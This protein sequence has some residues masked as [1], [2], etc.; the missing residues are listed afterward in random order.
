MEKMSGSFVIKRR[1]LKVEKVIGEN[2]IKKSVEADVTLPYKVIKVFDVM[3]NTKDVE[4]EVRH[5]GVDIS[6]TIHKQLFVVDK[7]DLVQHVAEDVPFQVY[8]PV[9]HAQADM[10]VQV[11]VRIL[12]VDTDLINARTV[13]QTVLLDIFVKVTVTEQIEV[14]TDVRGKHLKVKKEFLKVDSVVGEDL[15]YETVSPTFTLPIT[16]K[17]IFRIQAKLQDVTAETRHDS[18]TLRGMIHKQIYFV[19]EGDLVRHAREDIPFTKTINIPGARP[20]MDVMFRA[21]VTV[22]DAELLD[23]PSRRLSQTMVIEAFVKVTETLQLDVVVDVKGKNIKVKKKL[24]KV[25]SVVVDVLQTEMLRAVAKLPVQAQ[26]IFEI[27]GKIVDLETEARHGQV[28][29]KGVLH[30]QLFFVDPANLLRHAFEDVP[31]RFVK[32]APGT[33]PGMNVLARVR[34]IGNIK[35]KIVDRQGMKI[36]QTALLEVFVKVTR[37][38]QLE[39]VVDV[40]KEFP[41]HPEYPQHPERPQHPPD[42]SPHGAG[43]GTV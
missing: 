35:H 4:S 43:E 13:Q 42:H 31:F 21:K 29:V 39:V 26:K 12:E 6:G 1:L 30:K 14:V 10:N 5:G 9:K 40:K 17:K 15:V 28:L 18:V 20:D 33:S 27:V 36:E 2:S 3:A 23:A 32:T 41:Q 19:D 24:L 34:I 37:T 25:E 22:E 16:A 38:V 7:G 11:D 8:V